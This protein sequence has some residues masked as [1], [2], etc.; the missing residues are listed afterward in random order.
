MPGVGIGILLL[1]DKKQ[2]L[3]ILRNEDPNKALS[4]MRLEGTW[5]LPA[6]KVKVGE[7]IFEAA[8]RKTKQEVNLDIS[9]LELISVADDIN[10]YAH[11][12]TIGVLAQMYSGTIDLGNTEEHVDYDFFDLDKLPEN[13]CEPSRKIIDNYLN[14]RIYKEEENGLKLC[15]K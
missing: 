2:V 9:D 13:V 10:E 6:G 8:V 7:T 15:K 12:V 11:F 5:T 1:N 3:M 4:D 14:N